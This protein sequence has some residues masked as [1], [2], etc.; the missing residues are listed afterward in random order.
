MP[1]DLQLGWVHQNRTRRTRERRAGDVLGSLAREVR[2]AEAEHLRAV[3]STV[4]SLVD[5]AFMR[6]CRLASLSKAAMVVNVDEPA[7]VCPM[8]LRWLDALRKT[9]CMGRPGQGVRSIIFR[10]GTTGVII[11]Q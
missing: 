5:Q 6:H 3:I 10:Y 7:L 2:P 1:A 8:R 4:A 9:L 11:R